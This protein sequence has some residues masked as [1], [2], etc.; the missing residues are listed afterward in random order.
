MRLATLTATF[1]LLVANSALADSCPQLMNEF[2]DALVEATAKDSPSAEDR[3]MALG[4]HDEGEALYD[5]GDDDQCVEKLQ[6]ALEI[7]RNG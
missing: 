7:L 2:G 5:A 6:E 1:G 3:A 4:L